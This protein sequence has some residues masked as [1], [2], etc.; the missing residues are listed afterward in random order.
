MR[1]WL[2][3]IIT[4]FGF[5]QAEEYTLYVKTQSPIKPLKVSFKNDAKLKAS[6]LS[7]YEDLLLFNLKH[8]GYAEIVTEFTPAHTA[9]FAFG[10]DGILATIKKNHQDFVIQSEPLDYELNLDARKLHEFS[11]RIV[12]ALYGIKGVSSE[13]ILYAIQDENGF[14]SEIYVKYFDLLDET[15][16]TQNGSFNLTPVFLPNSTH[17]SNAFMYVSYKNGIPKIYKQQFGSHTAEPLI[18]LRGNHFLPAISSQGDFISFISDASGKVDLFIQRLS[19]EHTP[20]GKPIQV[21]SYPNSV[22]ATSSFHPLGE[23]LA[24]V[25]DHEKKPMIYEINLIKTLRERKNNN[26]KSL[27]LIGQECTCP[28][29]SPDGTKLAYVAPIDGTRQIWIYDIE[30]SVHYPLTSGKFHKENPSWASNNLHL[31]Y[32]TTAGEYEIYVINLNQKIPLKLSSKPGVKHYPCWE[33]IKKRK[34]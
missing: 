7:Q 16:V 5:L 30:T 27:V 29:W 33:R 9:V 25:S 3:L 14:S 4:V 32:N 2:S 15:K 23:T 26:L 34:I 11:D 12:E 13:R 17:P 10:K 24:F 22:Q 20:L 31:T 28:S 18:N 6:T 1:L 21:F 19:K 8:C